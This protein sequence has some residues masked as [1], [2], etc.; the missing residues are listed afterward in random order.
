MYNAT[1]GALVAKV[2]ESDSEEQTHRAEPEEEEYPLRASVRRFAAADVVEQA[3]LVKQ[4]RKDGGA[5]AEILREEEL[6]QQLRAKLAEAEKAIAE[7]A[8]KR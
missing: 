1:V 5:A 2:N 7:H 6:L 8:P 4:L 3:A